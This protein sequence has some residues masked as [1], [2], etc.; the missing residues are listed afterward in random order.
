MIGT[1]WWT[2]REDILQWRN[3]Y[4]QQ[5][6]PWDLEVERTIR[7]NL[8][9]ARTM[10][11]TDL[12]TMTLWKFQR[13]RFKNNHLRLVRENSEEAIQASFRSAIETQ[14]AG[15]RIRELVNLSGVGPALASVVLTF[16]DPDRHGVLD[17]HAWNE[18]FANRKKTKG[19]FT[20]SEGG[21]YLQKLEEVAQFHGLPA[22]DV[23]KALFMHDKTRDN[24]A[25]RTR[26][27][28]EPR[29]R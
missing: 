3:T 11:K 2:N 17:Y 19:T 8:Q 25:R 15:G 7:L 22:R 29:G 20:I 24:R 28:G 16:F 9:R 6:P 27:Q 10:A 23:E 5:Q 13:S 4:D 1:D 18:L 26:H 12:E 14:D 21:E